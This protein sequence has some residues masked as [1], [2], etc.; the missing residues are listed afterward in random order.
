MQPDLS[1]LPQSAQLIVSLI[2]LPATVLLVEKRGGRTLSLHRR[3]DS[4]KR[5][6]GIVGEAAADSLF[7]H[8]GSEPIVV[9]RCTA[10]LKNL[11]NEKIHAEFD[12]MTG[13]ERQ[14]ARAAIDTIVDNFGLTERQIWRILKLS[15][16]PRQARQK[17]VDERQLSLI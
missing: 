15:S 6:A 5:L 16:V 9:P 13:A 1:H 14:T 3:G 7:E 17:P 10:A 8:Y 2:G 4:V 12:R 11:R